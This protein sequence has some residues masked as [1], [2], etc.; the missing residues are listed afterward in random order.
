MFRYLYE[1]YMFD[2]LDNY[3]YW[4]GFG[5]FFIGIGG[6]VMCYKYKLRLCNVWADG[7]YIDW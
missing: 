5:I 2:W 6:L 1:V 3:W 7:I 4:G